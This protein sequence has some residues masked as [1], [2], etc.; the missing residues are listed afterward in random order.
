M[1]VKSYRVLLSQSNHPVLLENGSYPY[2]DTSFSTAETVVDFFN[3]MFSLENLA[4]EYVFLICF[5]SAMIPVGVFEISHGCVNQSLVCPREVFI[6]A[7]LCGAAGFILI[8]NHPSGSII[9]SREDISVCRRFQDASQM[10]GI[11]F[12]DFLI[13]GNGFYS[14]RKSS[15]MF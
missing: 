4:E 15:E 11:S 13:V 12:F 2:P 8:H 14:F 1:I 7:L 6:R 9:A 10:M 3:Q 5:N